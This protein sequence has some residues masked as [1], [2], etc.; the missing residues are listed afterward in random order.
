MVEKWGQT[1][2]LSCQGKNNLVSVPILLSTVDR[3]A[4]AVRLTDFAAIE[5]VIL[6]IRLTCRDQG[7]ASIQRYDINRFMV[8]GRRA[9]MASYPDR[10]PNHRILG[11][12][13]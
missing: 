10:K 5:A 6:P 4:F 1:L 8:I 3:R 9:A 7:A 2:F 11:G 13:I 12:S